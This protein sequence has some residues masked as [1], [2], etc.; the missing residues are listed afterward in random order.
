M[1][2]P[3]VGIVALPKVGKESTQLLLNLSCSKKGVAEVHVY[4]ESEGGPVQFINVNTEAAD[5]EYFNDGFIAT[6]FVAFAALAPSTDYT[7]L[8]VKLIDEY[9]ERFDSAVTIPYRTADANVVNELT[10]QAVPL[11]DVSLV[12]VARAKPLST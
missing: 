5:T 11:A 2:N 1:T 9:G 6:D 4:N 8:I 7:I 10:I 12:K 3:N